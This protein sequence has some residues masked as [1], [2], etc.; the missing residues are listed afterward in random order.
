MYMQARR[1]VFKSG[2]AVVRVSSEGTSGVG[3]EGAQEGA[4]LI[5]G[6]LCGRF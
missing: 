3:V 2:P 1:H 4:F 6:C 5:S